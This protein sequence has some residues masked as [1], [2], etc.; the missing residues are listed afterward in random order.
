MH[1]IEVELF[2]LLARREFVKGGFRVDCFA[3][4]RRDFSVPSVR[5]YFF[6]TP[7]LG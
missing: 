5:I 3:W 2:W 6:N 4:P 1:Y 7:W